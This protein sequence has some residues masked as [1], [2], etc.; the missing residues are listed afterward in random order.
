MNAYTWATDDEEIIFNEFGVSM[1]AI[2]F[3]PHL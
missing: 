2:A 1:T 3:D